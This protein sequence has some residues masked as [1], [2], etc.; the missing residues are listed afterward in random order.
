MEIIRLQ[1]LLTDPTAELFAASVHRCDSCDRL[2]ETQEAVGCFVEMESTWGLK[3]KSLSLRLKLKKKQKTLLICEVELSSLAADC[4]V[5]VLKQKI[6][7]HS[8]TI[9]H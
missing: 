1:N 8:V 5:A 4:F 9:T 3:Q 2:G 7:S 6:F